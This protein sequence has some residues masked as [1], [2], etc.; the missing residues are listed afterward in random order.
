[1]A[2]RW[3]E[4]IIGIVDKRTRRF[5]A[6][7]PA[8]PEP[9]AALRAELVAAAN[10]A[11]RYREALVELVNAQDHRVRHGGCALCDAITKARA[12]AEQDATS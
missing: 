9:T 3:E 4:T 12:L 5:V 11:E 6:R 8:N 1:M 7:L 10:A 2:D